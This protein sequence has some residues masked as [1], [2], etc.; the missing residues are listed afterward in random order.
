MRWASVPQIETAL[1]RARTSF[2]PGTG[3]A[4]SDDGHGVEP[5][6]PGEMPDREPPRSGDGD[7]AA[8]LVVER[9]GVPG[10]D[11]V[12]HVA[13]PDV[14]RAELVPEADASD[15]FLARPAPRDGRLDGRDPGLE[16]RALDVE[17][18]LPDH[19]PVAGH[20]PLDVERPDPLEGLD[21]LGDV[22]RH[23][24]GL[25]AREDRVAGE[26]DAF[27]GNVDGQLARRM[28]GRVEAVERVVADAKGQV[29]GEHDR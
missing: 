13:L 27:L 14:D 2:G 19:R 26:D 6:A 24:P 29:A 18:V 10:R 7:G 21:P 15:G 11:V 9:P 8:Q 28:A 20:D 23:E 5:R 25:A 4:T 16:M 12:H 3:T 17:V 1:T 22:R